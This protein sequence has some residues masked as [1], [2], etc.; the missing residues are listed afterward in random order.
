MPGLSDS[1]LFALSSN[2]WM[3]PTHWQGPWLVRSPG[4]RFAFLSPLGKQTVNKDFPR[5][6]QILMLKRKF[7]LWD[8]ETRLLQVIFQKEI[9]LEDLELIYSRT[10]NQAV[11]WGLD[12]RS[13]E[14]SIAAVTPEVSVK[15]GGCCE[16]PRNRADSWQNTEAPVSFPKTSICRK[17]FIHPL[18]M[19]HHKIYWCLISLLTCHIWC[20]L[21]TS[22]NCSLWTSMHHRWPFRVLLKINYQYVPL[23]K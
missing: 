6:M 13:K 22:L 17:M 20:P 18:Q 23:K 21:I 19:F 16:L 14:P 4:H 2:T 7:I 5:C 11:P 10:I 9:S 12:H 8:R 15:T 1:L 3:H